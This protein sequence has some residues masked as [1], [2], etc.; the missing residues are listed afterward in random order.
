[1]AIA[2]ADPSSSAR[3]SALR[4]FCSLRER[5]AGKTQLGGADAPAAVGHRRG[6]GCGVAAGPAAAALPLP[7]PLPLPG[8]GPEHELPLAVADDQHRVLAG[9]QRRRLV[10]S[11]PAP[12]L[13]LPVSARQDGGDLPGRLSPVGV[14]G[15]LCLAAALQDHDECQRDDGGQ[16]HRDEG[17]REA[18][19]Q[20]SAAGLLSHRASVPAGSPPRAR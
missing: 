1:M 18:E 9:G 11:R 8:R 7:R 17:D 10:E 3:H 5:V 16:R 14:A 6:D 12:R 20:G 2:I 15:A 13:A 19:A 4:S